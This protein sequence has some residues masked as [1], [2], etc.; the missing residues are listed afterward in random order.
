MGIWEGAACCSGNVLCE[1]VSCGFVS[2][3]C[4]HEPAV[5]YGVH[6]HN[7]GSRDQEVSNLDVPEVLGFH[8]TIHS[9]PLRKQGSAVYAIKYEK[10][11]ELVP[12]FR[13]ING[14]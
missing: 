7:V 6:F 9:G 11:A 12:A 2:H 10:V 14:V 3:S 1:T 5:F 4:S 13:F 8:H